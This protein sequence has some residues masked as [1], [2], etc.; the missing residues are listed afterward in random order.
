MCDFFG[1]FGISERFLLL[2]DRLFVRWIRLR[3]LAVDDG[4]ALAVLRAHEVA[5][6]GVELVVDTSEEVHRSEAIRSAA[7]L[8][9]RWVGCGVFRRLLIL[10]IVV[11][12]L[13][14]VENLILARLADV[15]LLSE[16]VRVD[17]GDGLNR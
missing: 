17:A 5:V 8:L 12:N 16:E 6:R 14:V 13:T 4:D 2:F 3:A 7:F 1:L 10:I 9:R 11:W 15:H